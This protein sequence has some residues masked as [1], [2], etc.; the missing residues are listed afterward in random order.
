MMTMLA[1]VGG[2]N[3]EH[4]LLDFA[5]LQVIHVDMNAIYVL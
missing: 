5:F 4:G 1:N 2:T 3:S